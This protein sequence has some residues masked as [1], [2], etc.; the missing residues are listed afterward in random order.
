[1]EY[2]VRELDGTLWLAVSLAIR[3][4]KVAIGEMSA[5]A[6]GIDR[7]QPDVYID[8]NALYGQ[9]KLRRYEELSKKNVKLVVLDAE[10]GIFYS[11]EAYAQRLSMD[12]LQ[13]VDCFLAWGDAASD[14]LN[15][16][17]PGFS[18]DRISLTGNPRFDLVQTK[19]RQYYAKEH[20][21]RS[22]E[23]GAYVLIN[24]NFGTA[25]HFSQHI[26]QETYR[27][28][29]KAPPD[30]EFEIYQREL[31]NHFVEG[32]DCLSNQFPNLGIVVRPH[33]SENHATYDRLFASHHN[34]HVECRGSVRSWILGAIVTIHNGCTTGIEGVLLGKPVIAFRPLAQSKYDQ[35]LP[36]SVSKCI[37][38]VEGL[39]DAVS[40]LLD[41]EK[42]EDPSPVQESKL[43]Y[44]IHNARSGV[45][46]ADLICRVIDNMD[47]VGAFRACSP[48]GSFRTRLKRQIKAM[49]GTKGME[50]VRRLRGQTEG[51]LYAKQKFPRLSKEELRERVD[52]LRECSVDAGDI[53]IRRIQGLECSYWISQKKRFGR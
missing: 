27:K 43:E 6:G 41:G 29:R 23:F 53:V 4:Y 18:P 20:M 1:M 25:N 13:Y 50:L 28:I 45:I 44:F 52:R 51:A 9:E 30:Q 32:I 47:N 37:H 2:K 49:L 26:S 35:S 38:T 17:R 14:T 39:C 10:G 3:G 8:G 21:K 42:W 34:V 24:T 36:N 11:N 46:S 33:P 40:K 48:L 12:I 5:I 22:E 19:F 15:T 31:L 7:I 16:Y